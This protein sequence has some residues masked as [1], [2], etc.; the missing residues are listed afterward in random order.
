MR[1]LFNDLSIHGQFG[2]VYEFQTAL[3]SLMNLRNVARLNHVNMC[4]HRT[5]LN[6]SVTSDL[7]VRSAISEL[8]RD[9]KL[10][11]QLW[12]N[13]EG[14]YW[15][16]ERVH[17]SDD[18]VQCKG[19]V[20]TDTA[21]GE[22]GLSNFRGVE[23]SLVSVVPSN[24]DF[25]PIRVQWCPDHLKPVDIE[26]FNHWE[27]ATLEERLRA[28]EPFKCWVDL[29]AVSRARFLRLVFAD[30]AFEPLR[31]QPF[32]EGAA[33]RLFSRFEVLEK[34][35]CCYDEQ[36]KRTAEGH[37]LYKDHFEGG[38]AWFSDSSD[39]EKVEFK[40]EMMFQGPVGTEG[41][42]S[43]PWHGKIKSSQLRFHFSWP[44]QGPDPVY[45][46]Y[47]GPKITKR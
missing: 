7:T 28:V 24:W 35:L 32:V 8:P 47:V 38:N 27:Q 41:K 29:E 9:K 11:F 33:N 22:A 23:C 14:P 18:Y 40:Q 10:A 44:A 26:V 17:G 4:C 13:K 16:D 46:V 42:L 31:A 5:L 25:S 45:V 12:W 15:D 37:A 34:I 21:V 30:N 2:N 6:R 39:S 19:D 36:G 1:L 20:V 43:Y 3:D